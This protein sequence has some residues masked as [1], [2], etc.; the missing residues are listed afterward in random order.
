MSPS[1]E[2][3]KDIMGTLIYMAPEVFKRNYDTKADIWSVGVIAFI[4]LT[5]EPPFYGDS[6]KEME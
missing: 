4:L 6:L 2:K 3:I 1:G 5:G